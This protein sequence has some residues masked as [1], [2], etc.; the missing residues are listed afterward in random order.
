MVELPWAALRAPPG[1]QREA[2]TQ[3]VRDIGK[4]LRQS[5]G[6]APPQPFGRAG[7]GPIPSLLVVALAPRGLPPRVSLSG[8]ILPARPHASSTTDCQA[9]ERNAAIPAKCRRGGS[10]QGPQAGARLKPV[11]PTRPCQAAGLCAALRRWRSCASASPAREFP[12]RR[13]VRHPHRR[14]GPDRSPSR[15]T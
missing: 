13:A 11:P 7:F 3:A 14:R 1:C 10:A 9:R 2:T 8:Q 12:R 5:G 15:R 4:E 6:R